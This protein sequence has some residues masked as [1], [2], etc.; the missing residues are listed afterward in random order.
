MNDSITL[1][2]CP[3]DDF[4]IEQ[5]TVDQLGIDSFENT[6]IRRAPDE[7]KGFVSGVAELPQDGVSQQ[8]GASGHKNSHVGPSGVCTT[9]Q[10]FILGRSGDTR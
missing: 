7:R 9:R 8:P 2:G 10:L 1:G 3:F 6:S 4:A 5:I